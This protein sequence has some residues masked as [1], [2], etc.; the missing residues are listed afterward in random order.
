MGR[1]KR[2]EL[3]GPRAL[4]ILPHPQG[5]MAVTTLW[6]ACTC[7]DTLRLL[8]AST[9]SS[10]RPSLCKRVVGA[11]PLPLPL[12]EILVTRLSSGFAADA[13]SALLCSLILLAIEVQC[14]QTVVVEAR[15]LTRLFTEAYSL[16]ECFSRFCQGFPMLLGSKLGK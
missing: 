10:R 1:V 2:H 11:S 7:A 9:Q 16:V 8:E 15:C 4:P 12:D 6:R 5:S 14:H 3:W 13:R